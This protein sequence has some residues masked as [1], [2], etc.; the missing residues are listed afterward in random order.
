MTLF[1]SGNFVA[2]SG[3]LPWKVE[4]ETL[5]DADWGWAAAR[6][7]E[8]VWIR[9]VYGVPTGGLKLANALEQYVRADGEYFLIVDDV[10]T[11]GGSMELARRA[12]ARTLMDIPRAGVVMF[13]RTTPAPW[14]NAIWQYWGPR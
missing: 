1:E 9:D 7:A 8:R 2:R 10:L 12:T 3:V 5:I 14:I 6:I 11:T 13:A 4:C